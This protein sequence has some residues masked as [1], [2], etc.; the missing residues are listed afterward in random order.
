M[1]I[2]EP[3]AQHR[4][5]RAADTGG[6]SAHAERYHAIAHA[7][8]DAIVATDASQRIVHFSRAAELMFG[9]AQDEALG[10]HVTLLLPP[11]YHALH[12]TRFERFQKAHGVHYTGRISELRG[13]KNNGEEFPFEMSL[14]VVM[15]GGTLLYTAI[16][17]D[18]TQRQALEERL[19]LSAR[20]FDSTHE[21]I[22]MTDAQANVVAVNPAFEQITGYGE[23]EVLG[24]NPRLLRSGRH[25]DAFYHAMWQSL[26]TSG[27]WRGEIWNRRKNGQVYPERISINA[28]KDRHG[29]VSAY[30]SVSSDVSALMDARS[31]LEFMSQHDALTGLPNR[32]LL[33]D[34]MR[35]AF[36][37][38]TRD[39]TL[40]AL[41]LLNIDRLQRINDSLGHEAGDALLGEVARRCAALAAP[42]DTLARLGSDEFVLML[43]RCASADDIIITT[44]RLIDTIAQP[45]P[46][47]GRDIVITASVGIGVFPRDGA[48]PGDMLKAADVA[49][50]RAKDEGR[51]GFRFFTAG[52]NAHALRTMSL[53]ADL[54]A[55][56]DA[57][58]LTLYYQPQVSLSDGRICGVEALARWHSDVH[59]HVAPSDFIALAED[60]GLIL[61]LG[62]WVIHQACRQNKA[63]Q[64]AGM[65]PLRLAVNVSARQFMAGTVPEVVR[66][67]LRS[68]GLAPDYLEVELTES[69]MMKDSDTTE[70][71]LAE[72]SAMGVSTSLDD[73]GTGYSCLAY[74]SRFTIDKLKI[75][76]SFVRTMVH[77]RR[78][79]AIARATVTLAHG[80]ALSVVA[81]GVETAEQL[82]LL[83]D[84]GCDA[85]Q[86]FLFSRPLPAQE[87][88][89]LMR[90][91]A[92]LMPCHPSS[93]TI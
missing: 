76:Q 85:S 64:D 52:M 84:I 2:I 26:H 7:A 27:Q 65:A 92:I 87:M 48:T 89:E 14:S 17:R 8:P 41:L 70:R 1:P 43:T 66:A 34:R 62:E 16:L 71:Q 30:V 18:I 54:R 33:S 46:M 69:V 31:E 3:N 56:I 9:Y 81:E 12:Q 4:S 13:R 29:Q 6:T 19:R 61:P 28:V 21:S 11:R 77:D 5:P 23:R 49:L 24:K 93:A 10:R 36:A 75:D 86:G 78:S 58:A 88:A 39:G 74:L 25:D 82:N 42:G 37:A 57:G 15:V 73:F 32:A 72:L 35:Q 47:A 90:K 38:A 50:A 55:A 91:S 45:L 20:V 22:M 44:S 60:T 80:L 83:C 51:N 68:S 53:E 40:V 67:A 59:G 63:W 79:A